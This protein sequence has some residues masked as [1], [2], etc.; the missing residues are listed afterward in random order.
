MVRTIKTIF[1]RHSI[2][3]V[4]IGVNIIFFFLTERYFNPNNLLNILFHGSVL[5]VVAI[6]E[7]ICLLTGKFDLSVG[8]LVALTGAIAAALGPPGHV[9]KMGGRCNKSSWNVGHL[10]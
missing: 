3:F 6:G 10:V 4:L 7:S 2:W 5:G 9:H 8:S 1:I